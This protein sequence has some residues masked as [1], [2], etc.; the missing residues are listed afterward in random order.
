MASPN[1]SPSSNV[2][3]LLAAMREGQPG[4]VDQIVPL[5]YDEL[6]AL[7]HNKLR[8]ERANHTL[9]T[10]ALVHE[11]YERLVNQR[12][13]QWQSRAHFFAIAAQSMRRVLVNY[14][15]KRNAQKRGGGVTPLSFEE[16]WG[17]AVEATDVYDV[18]AIDGALRRLAAFNERGARVVE[19]RFFGGLTYEEIAEVMGVS[20]ST[21][22]RAWATAKAWLHRELS[23]PEAPDGEDA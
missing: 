17:P 1:A 9:N 19:Y 2:T 11:A 7:A 12:E 8:Y 22:R 21:V 20:V 5:V 4:A 18:L 16:D 23:A 10:T 13:V 6:R 15:V 3:A 14:A